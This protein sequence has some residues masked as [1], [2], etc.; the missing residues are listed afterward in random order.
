MRGLLGAA[1][2]AVLSCGPSDAEAM[3]L[4]EGRNLD[5]VVECPA[6]LCADELE[7][8]GEMLFDYGRSPPLCL[9][10]DICAR[11]DCLEPNRRC[12]LF[13]GLPVQVRCVKNDD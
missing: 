2:A 11:V 12:V 10:T 3:K 4:K 1:L 7:F 9:T 5:D 6:L 8:C 13:D